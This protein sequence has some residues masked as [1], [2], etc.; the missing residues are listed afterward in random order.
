MLQTLFDDPVFQIALAPLLA[1]LLACTALQR[2]RLAWLSLLAAVATAVFYSSG[3]RLIP[4][5]ASH[6]ASLLLLAATPVGIALDRLARPSRAIAPVLVALCAAAPLWVF[7]SVLQRHETAQLLALT[8]GLALF[9]GSLVA[10]TL[11]LRGDGVAAAAATVGIGL[12]VGVAAVL[13]ASLGNLG[14]GV[15]LAAGGGALL[16]WQF[17]FGTAIAPGYL[18]TLFVGLGAALFT[19]ITFMLAELPWYAMP[20]LLLVPLAA[21]LK[22]AAQRPLRLRAVVLTLLCVA[23]SSATIGAAWIA[24]RAAQA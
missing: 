17:A 13:S 6:K 19:S 12:A 20:P 24:T 2:T 14:K 11:R 3:V 9:T 8:A 23:V 18:G 21:S 10:L 22:I 4:L 16:L 5:N 7:W 1:A 15:A